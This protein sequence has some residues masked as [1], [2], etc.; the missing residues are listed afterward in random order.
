[1]FE[2]TRSELDHCSVL[3]LCRRKAD[4]LSMVWESGKFCLQT[5]FVSFMFYGGVCCDICKEVFNYSR[6]QGHCLMKSPH[7]NI[8]LKALITLTVQNMYTK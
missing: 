4:P 5:Q 2:G 1:M 6:K 3:F 8:L 7:D